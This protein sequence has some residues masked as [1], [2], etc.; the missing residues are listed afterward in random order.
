MIGPR[1]RR[2]FTF[3]ELLVVIAII[4]VLLGLL[5]SAVQRVRYSAYRTECINNLRQ[6]GLA[7]HGYHDAHGSLPPGCSY[8]DGLDP[9]PHMSWQTRILPFLE[10]QALWEQAQKA[11]AE[12]RWFEN[13]PP[14]FGF[15][16]F[17][18][19]YFC[20]AD[21]RSF[22]SDGFLRAAPTSYLG[23]EGIDLYT[24]NGVLYLDSQVSIA[25]VT[26]GTSNT[27]AVGERPPSA[28]R[29]FGWW[30]A[31][32]GQDK[33]GS[34]DSV[35]GARERN[36]SSEGAGCPPGPYLFG[37]G[38]FQ[39]QCDAFHFW[40]PHTGGG[41]HFLLVDGSVHFLSYSADPILPALATRSGGEAVSLAD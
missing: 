15:V 14:H 28:Q 37:P 25:D 22:A 8:R 39:N 32:W 38:R 24:R 27:L 20:P 10:Q 19:L 3:I 7:L 29:N 2:G 18:R 5:L 6:M 9:Y 13:V 40:S 36:V 26:D 31:G 41:A 23:N 30:Y 16:T 4:G 1:N 12:D 34:G 33:G 35:L 11:F 17:V 21:A